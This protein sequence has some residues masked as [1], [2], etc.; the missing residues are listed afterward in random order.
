MTQTVAAL[1]QDIYDFLAARKHA[2]TREIRNYPQPIA[3]CDAQIPALWEARDA[4]VRELNRLDAAVE[5]QTPE[6][7]E[8]FLA[9]CPC[10]DAARK[11]TFED[12]LAA[13]RHEAPS[14]ATAE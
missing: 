6:A 13:L 9:A 5:D 10:L 11:R 2:V 8:A 14:H 4:L 1:W 3:G 12:A 7:V